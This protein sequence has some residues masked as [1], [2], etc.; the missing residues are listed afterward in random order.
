M[1][2]TY[3]VG[4]DANASTR[5]ARGPTAYI[6]TPDINA[7]ATAAD[8]GLMVIVV[9]FA[10]HRDVPVPGSPSTV[11]AARFAQVADPLGFLAIDRTTGLLSSC[12]RGSS[13]VAGEVTHE[14]AVRL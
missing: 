6:A 10:S 11:P 12:P 3:A 2:S 4:C 7:P 1:V 9:S 8:T 14:T 13:S 5:S